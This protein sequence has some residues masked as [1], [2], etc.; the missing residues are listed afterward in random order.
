MR[1]RT[2]D[3]VSSKKAALQNALKQ[4]SNL[5][6]EVEMLSEAHA[7]VLS[8]NAAT[9]EVSDFG[10]GRYSVRFDPR[11]VPVAETPSQ[12]SFLVLV[13]DAESGEH[14]SGSPFVVPYVKSQCLA[15]QCDLSID[16]IDEVVAG[17]VYEAV[18]H[19]SK[20]ISTDQV[21][22]PDILIRPIWSG[23]N[24]RIPS[25]AVCVYSSAESE[26]TTLL[27]SIQSQRSTTDD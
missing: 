22:V 25:Q 11:E 8:G 5:E 21:S 12:Q 23:E 6:N 19:V 13:V 14:I 27:F 4:A 16:H 10:N 18:I 1:K 20:K 7:A 17:E 24:S 3:T 9:G 2:E 26:F 15:S